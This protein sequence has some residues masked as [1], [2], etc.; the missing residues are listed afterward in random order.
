MVDYPWHRRLLLYPR[1]IEHNLRCA[2]EAG[3]VETAPNLWQITLGVLRMWHRLLFRPDTIGTSRHGAPRPTWR[4]RMLKPRPVRFPFLLMERAVA[5]LDF[6]GLASPPERIVRHLLGAHHDANQFAYDLEL[7]SCHE[8]KLEELLERARRVVHED[9]PRS[10]WLRDLTV[11]E[12]YHE[13]LLAAVER[14]VE[15]GV[16]LSD[17]DRDDPDISLSAYLGW[18]ARQPRTPAETWAARRIG[19][20]TIPGGKKAAR[21]LA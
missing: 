10:R 21:A 2:Q 18:C 16:T 15:H 3:L 7:L 6:S 5:P 12:G 9:T 19:V 13:R 14:A 20:Y 11:F 1:R 8:G 17:A 4:A